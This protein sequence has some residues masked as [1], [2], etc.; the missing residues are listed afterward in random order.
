MQAKITES[1]KELLEFCFKTDPILMEQYHIEAPSTLE[2]CV[3]RTYK[4]MV[5]CNDLVV[6]RLSDNNETVGYFGVE[7]YE[8]EHFLTGFMLNKGYRDDNYKSDFWRIVNET[9][10]KKSPEYF[11]GV[12]QKNN[13]AVDF[14][15]K[16]G[17]EEYLKIRNSDGHKIVFFK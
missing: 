8:G 11:C 2:R 7:E 13:R 6:Y 15:Q 12:Y 9:I 14:L 5:S 17:G 10:K 3:E 4:D 16:S 1:V